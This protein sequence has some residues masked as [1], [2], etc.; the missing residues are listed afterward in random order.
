MRRLQEQLV[1]EAEAH[2]R[3]HQEKDKLLFQ[4]AQEVNALKGE[5][6][7]ERAKRERRWGARPAR[8]I[9]DKAMTEQAI[10]EL[11]AGTETSG[12]M[13]AVQALITARVVELGDQ[14]T[15][16]PRNTIVHRDGSVLAG[17]SQDERMHDAGG[18]ANLAEMLARLQELAKPKPA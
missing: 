2:R 1:H 8:M 16:R 18:A 5:I 6:Q 7:L 9:V 12:L 3:E 15:D 11:L 10:E 4:A 17:Y 13:K 14:A